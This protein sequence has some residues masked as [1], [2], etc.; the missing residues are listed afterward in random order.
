[1]MFSYSLSFPL[2][3]FH[4]LNMTEA[5]T[6]AGLDVF[7]SFNRLTTDNK[8]VLKNNN[9]NNNNKNIKNNN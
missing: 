1:M 7:G 9:N 2:E 5:S 4:L 8:I 3:S 6:L